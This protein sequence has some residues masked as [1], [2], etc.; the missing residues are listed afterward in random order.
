MS[1]RNQ[2]LE[3]KARVVHLPDALQAGEVGVAV[4]FEDGLVEAGV[5]KHAGVE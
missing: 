3:N 5:G 1:P 4:A 2:A